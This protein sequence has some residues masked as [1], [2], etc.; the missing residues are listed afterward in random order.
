MIAKKCD[1]CGTL[2]KEHNIKHSSKCINAPYNICPK[3]AEEFMK[4]FEKE[5]KNAED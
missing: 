1:R 3:C 4:W 5:N 2:Y